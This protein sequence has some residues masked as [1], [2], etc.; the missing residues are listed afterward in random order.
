MGNKLDLQRHFAE[1][2]DYRVEGRC[3]HRLSDILL[4]ILCGVLADCDDFAQIA[5]YGK[6]QEAF[7]KRQVGLGLENGIP[8][9]DTLWRAMRWLQPEPLQ[10]CLQACY[11]AAF[12]AN[13]CALTA[14][15]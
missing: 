11:R 1:L 13:I 5:D 7:L 14:K 6:D 8:S 9:E 12:R 15:S 2:A 3:L 4:L 10:Q